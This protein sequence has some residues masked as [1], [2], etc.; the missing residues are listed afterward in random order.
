[1]DFKLFRSKDMSLIIQLI[2]DG[3]S[4]GMV[5]VL[6]TVGVVFIMSVSGIFLLTY[7]QFYTIGAFIAWVAVA[8]WGVP[9]FLSIPISMLV[10]GILG[11]LSYQFVF[12]YN[13]EAERAF[14]KMVVGALGL[15][16]ILGQS[17]L[18]V[19]GTI[20]R[21]LP[22]VFPGTIS[23]LGIHYTY[24]KL[25]LLLLALVITTALFLFL[26]KTGI[27]RAMRAVSFIQEAASLQ[28]INSEL[29]CLIACGIGTA[30]AGFA[31]AIMAPSYGIYTD[32]GTNI[33]LIIMLTAML[34]G[35]DSL[36]GAVIAGLV[37]G[38]ILSFGQYF[39]G[40]GVS[41]ILFIAIGIIIYLRPI[42][43]LGRGTEQF[44]L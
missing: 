39:I 44:G 22:S 29:M 13:R 9:F 1:M 35:T 11:V 14:E 3:I 16:L 33:I 21:G 40:T 41:I 18:I 34:G 17:S 27:G 24:D 10:T 15:L 28:G 2:L 32:M 8:R 36:P 23:V 31:G 5:Y 20:A 42:G 25:M 4:M 19:F 7:G 26:A 6:L 30:L 12:K 38:M 37:V 43:L